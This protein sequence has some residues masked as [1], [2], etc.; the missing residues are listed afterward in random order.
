[1][2]VYRHYSRANHSSCAQFSAPVLGVLLDGARVGAIAFRPNVVELGS[3]DPGQDY[4]L[5][6]VC[7]G[8]QNTPLGPY[9]CLMGLAGGLLRIRGEQNMTGGWRD[10]CQSDG[11]YGRS[12]DQESR[13]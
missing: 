6:I 13:N 8:T 2:L 7:Y 12:K 3:L 10:T 11:D 1:M 9:T 5:Q 4:E